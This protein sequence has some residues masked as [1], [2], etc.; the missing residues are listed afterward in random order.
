[1]LRRLFTLLSALSLLLCAATAALWA[2][3]YFVLD[4]VAGCVSETPTSGTYGQAFSNRGAISLRRF[5][6]TLTG[7]A[8]P[9]PGY[10]VRDGIN[11]DVGQ[12]RHWTRGDP[13]PWAQGRFHYL[14]GF[15]SYDGTYRRRPLR[16]VTQF[17]RDRGITLPHWL[18][19]VFA[20]A[21]PA[22]WWRQSRKRMQRSRGRAGLCE[23]CGYDL[24]G[25]PDRC[26]ECGAVPGGAPATAA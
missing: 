25:T 16:D 18:P 4:A 3:S 8:A 15:S 23:A 21:A 24:R 1:M 6:V 20:A 10:R 14:L 13:Q 17:E 22:L 5:D 11:I 19:M 12:Q 9:P 7:A 26:P 2:R